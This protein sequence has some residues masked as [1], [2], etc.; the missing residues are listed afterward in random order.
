[1]S[2]AKRHLPLTPCDRAP[3]F[4]RVHGTMHAY[5]RWG[6]RCT[7]ARDTRN[8]WCRAWAKT[9]TGRASVTRTKTKSRRNRPRPVSATGAL[10][11]EREAL[12]VAWTKRGD[13]AAKIAAEIGRTMRQVQRLRAKLRTQGRLS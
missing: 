4:A 5:S 2:G 12:V 13:S 1:M 10:R 8:A 9:P 3:H 7:A 11:A 6:C